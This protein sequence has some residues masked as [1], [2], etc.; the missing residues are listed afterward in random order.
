MKEDTLLTL[1]L[2]KQTS[3]SCCLLVVIFLLIAHTVSAQI[4]I[5]GVTITKPKRSNTPKVETPATKETGERPFEPKSEAPT[6][7]KTATTQ[8]PSLL[9]YFLS[10]ISTAKKDVDRYDPA[11]R[12]YLVSDVQEEWLLRAVSPRAREEYA[13]QMKYSEWRQANPGNRLDAA[14]DD[15]AAS[16]AKKLPI[17]KAKASA[18]QFRDPVAEKLLMGYFKNPATVKVHRI[19]VGGAGWLIQKGDDG[20]P[21]YRYKDTSVYLRDNSDDHPYCRV[22]SVRVKQDYAGGGTYST[23]TYRSSA[24]DELFGCP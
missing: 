13:K 9:D 5:G 19:G 3:I 2:T 17:Y 24:Q 11:D 8:E 20:L 1:K 21:S 7:S 14:L 10:E 16:A 6:N 15:L 4:T 23:E 18:F 12:R 22:I